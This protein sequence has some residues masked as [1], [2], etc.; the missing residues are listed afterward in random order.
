M[1]VYTNR[2]LFPAQPQRG[3]QV[4]GGFEG[5]FARGKN[6]VYIGIA[7]QKFTKAWL[8]EHGGE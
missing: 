7:F 1:E 5:T 8:D 2:K 3:A 4:R 6:L